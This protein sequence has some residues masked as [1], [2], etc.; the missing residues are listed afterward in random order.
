MKKEAWTESTPCFTTFELIHLPVYYSLYGP[1]LRNDVFTLCLEFAFVWNGKGNIC[2]VYFLFHRL[3]LKAFFF[4][5]L[6]YIHS[7]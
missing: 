5:D 2:L 1:Q 6:W 4:I 3:F 7:S